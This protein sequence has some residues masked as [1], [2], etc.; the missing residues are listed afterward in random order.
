M[1]NEPKVRPAP[2]EL[3]EDREVGVQSHALDAAHAQ[4]QQRPF[5][6][7]PSELALD[8]STAA[9]E[10]LG[11]LR[12]ARDERVQP[13][14]LD[15][16]RLRLAFAGRA[17]PL[18]C[19]A[20][21]VGPGERPLAVLADARL[22]IAAL[23]GRGLAK[24]RDRADATLHAAVVDRAV[25]VALV[26]DRGRD[27]EPALAHRVEQAERERR[28]GILGRLDRPRHRQPG[29]RV[30]GRVDLVA[31]VPA[32]L[33][34]RDGRAVPPRCV[35]VAVLARGA[36]A[37]V[38]GHEPLP[39]GVR[40]KVRPV[41]GDALA[42]AGVRVAQPVEHGRDA[43]VQ[44]RLVLAQLGREAV[45][46]PLARRGVLAAERRRAARRAQRRAERCA[47]TSGSR[48]STW[49]APCRPSRGSGSRDGPSSESRQARGSGPQSRASRAV[50]QARS[51]PSAVLLWER[52]RSLNLRGPDPRR[53]HPRGSTIGEEG[54]LSAGSD[55]KAP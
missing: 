53:R 49:R 8:G 36:L 55:G 47:S 43:G 25:V 19:L 14:G 13:V 24:R 7:Q 5:V 10:R 23:D 39:V 9:V 42:H 17:A 15:P 37:A 30:H 26:H 2:R 35:R 40:G 41:D 46:R 21:V 12:V 16:C 32:A 3:G 51:Q 28:L 52:P 33:A 6:L 44:Q 29:E 34:R 1:R 11:P 54:N 18:G 20:L 38:L 45:A 50:L 48:T 4:R 31:V 22:V 27:R